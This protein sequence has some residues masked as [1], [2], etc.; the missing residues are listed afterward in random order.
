MQNAV[1]IISMYS[2]III[3]IGTKLT[4]DKKNFTNS[5]HSFI[6]LIYYLLYQVTITCFRLTTIKIK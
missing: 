6:I 4:L 5:Q 1:I 3:K 2:I